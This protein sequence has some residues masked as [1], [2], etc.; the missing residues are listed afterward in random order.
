MQMFGGKL[1]FFV[2]ILHAAGILTTPIYFLVSGTVTVEKVEGGISIVV[3]ATNSYGVPVKVAYNAAPATAVE[4]TQV[5]NNNARKMIK[6]NK[7]YILKEGIQYNVLG[8]KL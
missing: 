1:M 3:D 2:I 8:V 4:N 6:D 7:I 5:V